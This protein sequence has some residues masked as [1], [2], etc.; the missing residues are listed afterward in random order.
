MKDRTTKAPAILISMP[1]LTLGGAEASVSQICRQLRARG[2][3]IFLI[4]TQAVQ[5]EQGDTS[6]WFA[7]SV[8]EIHHLPRSAAARGTW[9]DFVHALLRRE[10][11]DV[12][13]QV[14]STFMYSMLPQLRASFPGLAVVDLLFNP[15][16]HTQDY[17]RSRRFIDHVVVEH[18]GMRAWLQERGTAPSRISVIANAIDVEWF[19]P[20]PRRDWRA[21]GSRVEAAPARFVAAFLGRLSEEKGP[22]VF[23]EI[24]AELANDARFDFLVCGTGPLESALRDQARGAGLDARVHFPGRV[25]TREF[26]PYCDAVIVCSRLDGRPNIVMESLAMGIPVV[27]SRVGGIPDLLPP[28]HQS[29]LCDSGD[30]AGFA[31]AIRALADDEELRT[32]YSADA[33]RHAEQHFSIARVGIEYA[34]LFEILRSQ[35]RRFRTL[36]RIPGFAASWAQAVKTPP[37]N[38]YLMWRLYRS[39]AWSDVLLHFDRAFY[40]RE[41]TAVRRWGVPGLLHY[42]FWG[43]PRGRDPSPQFHT[44]SYLSANPDVARLGLN[45]LLHYVAFGREEGRKGGPVEAAPAQTC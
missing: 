39:R 11:V 45:P 42:V 31:R 40:A 13:W 16:G 19:A 29:A 32:S 34:S 6:A 20:Q 27:A 24:A 8:E 33:R 25:S 2:F 38:A 43:S 7:D 3:R 28:Q 21:H 44:S 30:V 4:T 17:L 41:N 22:D 23:L 15:E 5:E 37:K 1:Y 35:R 10:Q 9:T 14:G 18:E 36:R 12:L 26:L